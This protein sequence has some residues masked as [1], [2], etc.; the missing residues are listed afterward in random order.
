M[1]DK[2]PR[3]VIVSADDYG[4]APGVSDGIRELLERG[5]L[6]ATSCMTASPYWAEHAARLEPCGNYDLG[7]H[8]TLTDQ[9]PLTSMPELAPSGKLPPPGRLL[10]RCLAGRLPR[11]EVRAEIA[12]QL[13]AFEAAMGRAPDHIDGHHQTHQFPVVRDLVVEAVAARYGKAAR[14]PYIRVCT[15][16]PARVRHP[17][18]AMRAL[19]IGW[20]AP[21]L[22]RRARAAGLPV[23]DGFAGV[24][25]FDAPAPYETFF[26]PFLHGLRDTTII[27]CHPG[28]AD[29]ALRN[30]DSLIDRREDEY[31][32]FAGDL[33]PSLLARA[34]AVLSRFPVPS[35]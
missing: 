32:F 18:L 17:M 29:D 5:R 19:G 8:L 14:R 24:Y 1:T 13:D 15:P 11:D 12:A 7:V 26:E 31:R 35:P 30:L 23:N 3:R 21:R 28:H 2:R 25:D 33:Y 10:R 34:G 22:R 20:F 6:S 27:M 16:L 4:L 9:T